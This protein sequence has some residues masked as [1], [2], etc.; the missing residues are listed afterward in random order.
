MRILIVEDEIKLSE[1][2]SQILTRNRYMTDVANDG[3]SGLDMA[4]D[5]I[6]DLIILDVMLPGK[7]GFE[8]LAEIRKKGISTPVLLLTAKN[9][10]CDKV[11]GLDLGADDYMT[12]PFSTEELLARIRALLRRNTEVV[13]DNIISCEDISLNLSTYEL[14]C[15]DRS[16]KLGAKEMNIIEILLRAGKRITTKEDLIVKVW[17]YDSEAEYNNVEVYVSLLR[18]KLLHI[19]AKA[20]IKTVRGV[21][22]KIDCE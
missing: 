13:P 16:I 6:Y 5:D 15:G 8:I 21:G 14:F 11:N 3:E 19:H 1:A 17:G 10:I 9:E 4:L 20:S 12:K 7:S 2:L 22:Y 18:K